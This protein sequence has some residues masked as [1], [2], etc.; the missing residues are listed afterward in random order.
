MT[1]LQFPTSAIKLN[2]YITQKTVLSCF[3]LRLKVRDFKRC[4]DKAA[5][6]GNFTYTNFT[7]KDPNP[8]YEGQMF[9]DS[10][11]ASQGRG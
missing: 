6:A 3:V 8:K 4:A 2:V 10:D 5:V 11:A 1:L 7:S 9:I